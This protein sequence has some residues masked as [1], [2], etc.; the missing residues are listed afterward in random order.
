MRTP[1]ESLIGL[2]H[3]RALSICV[4]HRHAR[5]AACRRRPHRRSEGRDDASPR[6][7]AP[8]EPRN[9]ASRRGG[10]AFASTSPTPGMGNGPGVAAE[11]G[12]AADMLSWGAGPSTAT[13]GASAWV[14][15]RCSRW[16]RCS[17]LAPAARWPCPCGPAA[18][19]CWS[20]F[21]GARRGGDGGVRSG[22]DG[23]R[24]T[25][26]ARPCTPARVVVVEAAAA[27]VL[28]LL[29]TRALAVG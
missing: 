19:V 1:L 13:P 11:A 12:K 27:F 24:G 14:S 17:P 26:W 18:A 5:T 10:R 16:C 23:G 21:P 9:G 22:V 15:S 25:C 29:L 3:H 4:V 2:V 8:P 28:R 7:S 6:P 20:R